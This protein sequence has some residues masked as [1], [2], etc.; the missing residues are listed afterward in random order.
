MDHPPVPTFHA[1]RGRLSAQARAR[2]ADLGPRY[3]VP[4]GLLESTCDE[5]R[6]VL[7]VGC[8][9]GAATLAYAAAD[10]MATVV[11][12]DVY[13]P[14]LARLLGDAADTGTDH[15][16]VHLGDAVTLLRERV[17]PGRLT[18]VHLF[19]P[20]PWPKARHRR[21]RFV[22]AGTL[23]LLHAA[24]SPRGHVLLAT[25]HPAYAAHVEAQVRAHGGFVMGEVPRPGWRP[26]A[27]FE[28][29]ARRAA[30]PVLD[31]RLDRVA[32]NRS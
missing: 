20:D 24:L 3:A 10:P 4:A 5:A 17:A 18:A 30:R 27:G 6:V 15:V 7:D 16:Y 11:G 8:G 12:V 9:Y 26:V 2:L 14:G 23:D 29:V 32:G 19:F 25:D 28:L 31:L 1:R 21:R 13:P 22:G